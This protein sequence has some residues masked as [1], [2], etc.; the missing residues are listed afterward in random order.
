MNELSLYEIG[1]WDQFTPTR[2]TLD[3]QKV[4]LARKDAMRAV[5]AGSSVTSAAKRY[6]VNVKTLTKTIGNARSLASDGRPWGWR[7]CIPYRVRISSSSIADEFP[8]LAGPGAFNAFLKK[9]PEFVKLLTDY[10]GPLSGRNSPSSRFNDFFATLRK[11]I[12]KNVPKDRYPANNDNFARRSIM[13]F[14]RKQREG[15]PY[16][17][18]NFEIEDANAAGQ[19]S[20]VFALQLGDWVQYDGHSLD[21]PFYVAGED[22]DGHPYLQKII[23]TWLLVG[24]FALLRLCSSWKL[25]F[26][27]NYNGTDFNEA[28]TK[29]LRHWMPRDLVV[30]TMSYVPGSGIGTAPAIGIVA[31]PAI[32]SVDNAMAHRLEV[33]RQRMASE[34]LGV[35]NLGRAHVPEARGHLE[36]WNK[37]IEEAAIRHLPGAYRPA[38]KNSDKAVRTNKDDP[39]NFPIETTALEDLMD[40]TIS[41]S[42]VTGLQA[43]QGRSPLQVLQT[44]VGTGGWVFATRDNEA[45]AGAMSTLQCSARISGSKGKRRQPYARYSNARYRSVSLKNRWDLVGKKFSA[46]IDILDGRFLNLY[47]DDG[48]LFVVLRALRPWGQTS[49]SLA[50]RKIIHGNSYK[51]KFEIEG[52]PCAISAYKQYLQEQFA[53]HKNAATL[54]AQH[55]AALDAALDS[56]HALRAEVEDA[57]PDSQSIRPSKGISEIYVP[58]TGRVSLEKEGGSK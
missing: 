55:G 42:N 27:L 14:I 31:L 36:A 39:K 38:G 50:L 28:C 15:Q 47:N 53:A 43:F 16:V 5:A 56:S 33:N 13:E 51:G 49:H 54:T 58:L 1:Q 48:E 2:L 18:E 57:K 52:A 32:T 8:K 23:R 22:G 45:R 11:W 44:F 24:Y 9:A 35:V 41:G 6:V 12:K 30:P 3:Q 29:S 10:T 26:G 34:M 25:S 46:T 20:E 4:F 21:C 37:K 17:D 7:A 19:L 40:V